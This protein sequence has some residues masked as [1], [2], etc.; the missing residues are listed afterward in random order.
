MC[1]WFILDQST[2]TCVA[3]A[4]RYTTPFL[5]AT[6]QDQCVFRQNFYHGQGIC[7][8]AG[9]AQITEETLTTTTWYGEG[10]VVEASIL[11]HIGAIAV[12]PDERK[13]AVADKGNGR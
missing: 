1:C 8:G 6:S 7:L 11:T 5:G 4:L 2:K 10:A 13:A 9:S 3:C 12:H